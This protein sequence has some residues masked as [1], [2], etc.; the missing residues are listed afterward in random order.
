MWDYVLHQATTNPADLQEILIEQ[1]PRL[2]RII[3]E[4]NVDMGFISCEQAESEDLYAQK[5]YVEGVRERVTR[6]FG[7]VKGDIFQMILSNIER[8]SE[9]ITRKI[10]PL[11]R[12]FS[13]MVYDLVLSEEDY[14]AFDSATKTIEITPTRFIVYKDKKTGKVKL[15]LGDIIRSIGHE[16]HHRLQDH[17]SR[18]MPPGLQDLPGEYNVTGRTII[19]GVPTVLEDHFMEWIAD[20]TSR[21]GLSKKDVQ[22]AMLNGHEHW[23]NRIIRLVHSIYHREETPLESGED[24]DAHLRIAK[25]SKVPVYA[26]DDYLDTESMP[27]TYYYLHYF[28]GQMYVK[29]TLA[30]LEN[31]EKKRLG[32]LRKARNYLKKNEP[33]VIQGLL[34][35]NWGW[36]THQDFVLK[37]Y[38]PK[39][40][41]YC[42]R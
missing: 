15:Y 31:L 1:L 41:R 29:K 39:A 37:H 42:E 40:R 4:Y 32:S 10:T 24:K 38:W 14:C 34:T 25:V 22:I 21:Y 23:A 12:A 35:G 20:N 2:R 19:E 3:Q 30:A 6:F 8:Q 7:T 17:F 16:N 9:S 11:E 18:Y 5:A 26:D 36:S 28:F 33:L 13:E 27:E